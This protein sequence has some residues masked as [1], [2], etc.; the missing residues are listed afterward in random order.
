MCIETVRD[1]DEVKVIILTGE[2]KVFSAGGD[3]S[4]LKEIEA[5]AGVSLALACDVIVPL[6]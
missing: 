3:L 2:G 6:N 4:S 1:N 5:V